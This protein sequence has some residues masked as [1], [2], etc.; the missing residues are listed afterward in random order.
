MSK[1]RVIMSSSAQRTTQDSLSTPSEYRPKLTENSSYDPYKY[2]FS[3]ANDV[4]QYRCSCGRFQRLNLTYLCRYCITLRC[5]ACVSHEVDSQYCQHCLEYIPTIDPKFQ[6]NKCAACYI[7]PWCQHLLTTSIVSIIPLPNNDSQE[8]QPQ[9]STQPSEEVVKRV[10]Q[11]ICEFCRWSSEKF[12]TEGSRMTYNITDTET[13][14]MKWINKLIE[15][16]KAVSQSEKA[17]EEKKKRRPNA[18]K[19]WKLLSKHSNKLGLSPSLLETLRNQTSIN[20][21]L[22][23][24]D[25][26][27]NLTV[28]RTNDV[29]IEPPKPPQSRTLEE[30]EPL[31]LDFYYNK[32]LKVE[33]ISSIEQ[34]FAQID[35]QPVKVADFKPISKS[36]SVKRLIRCKECDHILCRGEYSPGAIRFK[37]Q[38]AA[39]Y[40]I[41]MLKLKTDVYPMKL[42]SNQNNIVE[43][44]LQN[45]TLSNIK[46]KIANVEEE[47]SQIYQLG[48]PPNEMT[49]TARDESLEYQYIPCN[50]RPLNTETQITFQSPFKLGFYTI[51]KPTGKSESLSIEFSLTHNVKIILNPKDGEKEELIT[52]VVRAVLGTVD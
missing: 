52:Q 42:K 5:R 51:V 30:L 9:P 22:I 15:Y 23:T 29:T 32:H 2:D 36:L 31:D 8:Q 21:K 4:I 13:P 17:E 38:S 10:C 26:D 6:M 25:K 34:R 47:S 33:D 48:L 43:F 1:P 39:Y 46:V 35:I 18:H 28:K 41:P 24:V 45:Q 7:C 16:Y 49:L 20:D 50:M 3:F 37:I 27:G 12:E 40:S 11:L 44:T 19:Q 14:N